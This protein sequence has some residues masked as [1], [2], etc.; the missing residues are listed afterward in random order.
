MVD[1]Q[2]LKRNWNG[3]QCITESK[4]ADYNWRQM[5]WIGWYFEYKSRRVL[6]DNYDGGREIAVA[7]RVN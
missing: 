5:E 4:E 3:K 1:L 7:G 6:L 2:P